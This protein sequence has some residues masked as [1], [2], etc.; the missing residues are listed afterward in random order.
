MNPGGDHVDADSLRAHFVRQ[1]LVVGIES[2]LSLQQKQ[3]S[4]HRAADGAEWTRCEE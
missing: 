3:V 2:H 1:A 4:R